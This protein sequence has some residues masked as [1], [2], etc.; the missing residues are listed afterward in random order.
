MNLGNVPANSFKN[1]SKTKIPYPQFLLKMS[2]NSVGVAMKEDS[3][4]VS[5][6]LLEDISMPDF[7]SE[8]NDVSGI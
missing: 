8:I 1:N 7:W 4:A 3:D 6:L 5:K 2:E